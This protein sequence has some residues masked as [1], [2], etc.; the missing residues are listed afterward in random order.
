M[1]L[2]L[3]LVLALP[4]ERLPDR[5]PILGDADRMTAAAPLLLLLLRW[6]GPERVRAHWDGLADLLRPIAQTRCALRL[7]LGRRVSPER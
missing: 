7:L 1:A 4:L 3:A 2:L 5:D 6:P